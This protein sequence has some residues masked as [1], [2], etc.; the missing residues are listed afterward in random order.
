MTI[1]AFQS[2]VSGPWPLGM[3]TV[4]TSGTPIPLNTNVGPQT[5]NAATHP[6]VTV[7]QLILTGD[8][9][10]SGAIYLL[11]KVQGQI[12]TKLTTNFIV[13]VIYP[14]NT[15]SVPNGNVSINSAINPDDY[16]V[17]ADN[18]GDKVFVTAITG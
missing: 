10:N 16:V 3:I 1:T 7:R 12:V 13:Q 4:A 2:P 15:V 17:D 14:G 11:R 8:S 18:N 5:A 9:D 6:T